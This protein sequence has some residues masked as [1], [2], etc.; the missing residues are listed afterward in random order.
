MRNLSPEEMQVIFKNKNRSKRLVQQ[1][2]CS[3]KRMIDNPANHLNTAN[4]KAIQGVPRQS[5]RP[6]SFPALCK[7]HIAIASGGKQQNKL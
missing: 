1:S 3:L 2:I 5:K 6:T 4:C 7:A